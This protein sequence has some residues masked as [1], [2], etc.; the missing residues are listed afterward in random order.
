MCSIHQ[1]IFNMIVLC[2][3][4]THMQN[5]HTQIHIPCSKHFTCKIHA[6][7]I[8]CSARHMNHR[9]ESPYTHTHT[10]H[11]HTHTDTRRPCMFK[12]MNSSSYI[13]SRCISSIH[14]G[15]PVS[16]REHTVSVHVA[17]MCA[18]T[19]TTT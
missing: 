5:T 3:S 2:S 11:T 7:H 16:W 14:V 10:H 13:I 19:H 8:T 18:R 17:K 9:P 6:S 4:L 12:S 1:L 15:M